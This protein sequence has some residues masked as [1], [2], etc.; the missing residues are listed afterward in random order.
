MLHYPIDGCNHLRNVD[1]A[2]VVGHLD[3]ENRRTRSNAVE[4]TL[5]LPCRTGI[6]A[7]TGDD[8]RHVSAVPERIEV[9]EVGILRFKREI[10]TIDHFSRSGQ[11]RHRHH[12]GVNESDS[13][14]FTV[15]VGPDGLR[16]DGLGVHVPHGSVQIGLILSFAKDDGTIAGRRRIRWITA[17][18]RRLA[19]QLNCAIR[20]NRGNTGVGLENRYG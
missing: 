2:F 11:T 6:S 3:V 16:L 19:H 20:G 4:E 14:T 10:W 17:V 18:L 12:P 15:G 13:H 1:R 5:A 7:V 9:Q 8:A